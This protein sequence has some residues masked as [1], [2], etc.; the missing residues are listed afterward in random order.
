MLQRLSIQNLAIIDHLALDFPPGFTVLT[1]ETGAGKS[2]ILGA[3]NLVLGERASSD[4][5]RTGCDAAEVEA[6]FEIN[7]AG[8]A[9][10]LLREWS[11]APDALLRDPRRADKTIELVIRR[12]VGAQGKSRCM[13][14][15]RA[16]TLAQLASLGDLLVDLHGQHQ[17]QS[18]L[19]VELHREILDSFG[20][21][22]IGPA[23][24][25]W[26]PLFKRYQEVIKRLRLLERGEREIE[27][28]KSILEFQIREIEEANLEP[29][30]DERLAGERQR[31]E[32]ADALRRAA[33]ETLDLLY[34]G[35]TQSPTAAELLGRAENTLAAAARLDPALEAEANRAAAAAA[36][37]SETAAFL[38]S[39]L[40]R[41][42]ADPARL[43]EVDDRLHLL[44]KLKKKYGAD[45]A[46]TLAMLDKFRAEHHS[47]AHSGEERQALETERAALEKQLNAAAN[48][49]TERRRETAER[50]AKGIC[51][52]LRELEM[53][54]VEFEARLTRDILEPPAGGASE[55]SGSAGGVDFENGEEED[56]EEKTKAAART[57][58][59]AFLP[60]PGGKRCRVFEHGADL[61]EFLISANRGEALKPLR[62]IAS[63]GEL[64]RIMLALKALISGRQ[65]IPTLVFDEIDTGISGRTGT[66]IGEKME[67]LARDCQVICISHLPQIAARARHHFAVRK[68]REKNRMLT[69]VI[70]LDHPQRLE[71]IARLLGG[72]ENSAIARTHAAEL[73]NPSNPKP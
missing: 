22:S 53:S 50:F 27:R 18:L 57:G 28:Q 52:H 10:S 48:E 23:L 47:L 5:V 45:A 20:A 8:A 21:D 40:D 2:I 14:N 71:E 72:E 6:L 32:H 41:L 35:E 49:L 65:Q 17:H 56:A 34:E 61:V 39:Y 19:R 54:A 59:A 16:I 15:G 43:A 42:D 26:A 37:L 58:G 63:G 38:R 62:K 3:L 13:V 4:D 60:L 1:G 46:E 24:G 55:T 36:E 7:A 29:G 51:K 12:E 67:S 70:P 69:R 30:E 31:L 64:S 44:K 25:K 68:T 11:L 9:A 66:R 33:A 73:L